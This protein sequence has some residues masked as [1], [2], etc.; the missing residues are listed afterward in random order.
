MD[1]NDND[2]NDRDDEAD[3]KLG[4]DE[5]LIEQDDDDVDN[6]AMSDVE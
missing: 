6:A 2:A 5:L 1:E 3:S 4:W